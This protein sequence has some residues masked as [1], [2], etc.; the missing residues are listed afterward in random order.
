MT[1]KQYTILV[2]NPGSTSTKVAVYQ[3]ER[4]IAGES[5]K[6]SLEELKA[7]LDI[8]DQYD[9]RKKTIIDFMK[10]RNLELKNLDVIVCRGGNVKPIPGGIY[11]VTEEMLK[12]IRS[13]CFGKHPTGVGNFIAYDLGK[14]LGI[15]V[16]TMDPPV[17]DEMISL[18][19]Y[20]GHVLIT[21]QSSFHALNQKANARK[22][23]ADLGKKYEELRI[24]VCHLGGGISVG[25]HQ[26]GKIIDANNALDGDG[27]FSPERAGSL[28]TGALIKLCFSGK[29][30]ER[31]V[32]KMINGCGGLM[33]YLGTNNALEVETLIKNGHEKAREVFEAMA[34]QT[35]KEIGSQAAVLEGKVDAIALCGSLAYSELFV[36]MISKRVAFIAPIYLYPG[37]NEVLALAEGALR[38]LT[39][40]EEAKIY[41]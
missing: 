15:P 37:E 19:K 29:Y 11:Y 27:P 39:R 38:F 30:T 40:R 18:A 17:T 41:A 35:A 10:Q 26:N 33:S 13:E 5:I 6:H 32:L 14:E 1:E 24:I 20:S 4:Q 7:H 36:S 31:E 22:L 25:A 28:P 16:I 2:I 9:F 12:D 34:F 8:W 3:N 21:R 23:A